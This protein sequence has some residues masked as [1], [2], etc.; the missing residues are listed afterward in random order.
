MH[1]SHFVSVLVAACLAPAC[2]DARCV[3]RGNC[4]IDPVS[5]KTIPC[6]YN[7]KPLPVENASLQLLKSV[8]PDLVTGQENAFCCDEGNIKDLSDGFTLMRAI[9]GSCP[10]CFFNLARVFCD[11]T[12]SPHQDTFLE[13]TA[14]KPDPDKALVSLNYYMTNTYA[15]GTF[16]SCADLQLGGTPV[17]KT[18]CWSYADD[19]IPQTLLQALGNHDETHSPFQVNFVFSENPV[20]SHGRKYEPMDD[21]FR[22]CS[23]PGAPGKAPCGCSTCSESCP[24]PSYPEPHPPF[25]IRGH[26]GYYFLSGMLYAI[27]LVCVIIAAGLRCCLSSR[28]GHYGDMSAGSSDEELLNLKGPTTQGGRLERAL[29][30]GFAY[31]GGLCARHPFVVLA[32]S[33]VFVVACCCGLLLFTIVTDPVELWSAPGSQARIERD[34]FNKEFGPFYRIQQVVITRNG[35]QPFDY[36]V[37]RKGANFTVTFGA[38]FE[39]DFL[40]Q[41]AS[42]Q[43]SLLK[44]NAE[45]KGQSVHIEDIC[46]SPLGNG[47]CMVQSPLGWFQ[48]NES[49]LDV[50]DKDRT[51]LD[52]LYYCFSGALSTSDGNFL[53]LPCLASYGGP[54]FPY[55]ALG[56]VS[57]GQY[58]NASAL[59][60]TFLV[61]N[62]LDPALVAP[63]IAWERL[64][65]ETLKNFSNPNMSIA[66]LSEV[67]RNLLAD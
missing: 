67:S 63:A 56:G 46:F 58:A 35:G 9:V 39:R 45:H 31:W 22:K 12:C 43:E 32:A 10:S 15:K 61:N 38:V 29:V 11:M 6:V 3:H 55:V 14:K 36:T 54:V 62:Y 25:K 27:F 65:I 8:C 34:L 16:D 60:L 28:T 66:F 48:N 2:V 17:V 49:L 18:L 47:E 64:F 53:G 37:K 23:E 5:Q 57:S 21:H 13:V 40:H 26:N 41:V 42:F 51:Y 30:R 24:E 19:C 52:H 44:L 33:V 4:G 59:V 1:I 7:G 20:E 50:P